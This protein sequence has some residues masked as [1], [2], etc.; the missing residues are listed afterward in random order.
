MVV[1]VA[2][3]VAAVVEVGEVVEAL[4]VEAV[5]FEGEPDLANGLDLKILQGLANLKK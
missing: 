5:A 3:A 4:E 2:D 1:V